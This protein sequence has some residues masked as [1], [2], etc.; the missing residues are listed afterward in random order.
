MKNIGTKSV[1]MSDK[2]VYLA[3]FSTTIDKISCFWVKMSHYFI[4]PWY[5]LELGTFLISLIV[6]VVAVYS[7]IEKLSCKC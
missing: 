5:P 4:S 7:D 2:M 6:V 3:M 1:N